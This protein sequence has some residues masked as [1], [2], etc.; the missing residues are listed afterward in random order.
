MLTVEIKNAKIESTYLGVDE[1]RMVL[2][3]TLNFGD[4]VKGA[5]WPTQQ[6][7]SG[8]IRELLKC[9]EIDQWESLVGTP[10]RVKGT[11]TSVVAIGHF[12][13]DK[14]FHFIQDQVTEAAQP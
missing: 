3:I 6:F 7:G 11:F 4:A 2:R 8:T 14:W 13:E 1:G 9:L 10:V 12:I 5:N